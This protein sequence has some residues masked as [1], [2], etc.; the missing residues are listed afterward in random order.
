MKDLAKFIGIQYEPIL[1]LPSINGTILT[2]DKYQIIGKI[3]Q[4]VFFLLSKANR[5]I[6]IAMSEKMYECIYANGV[7]DTG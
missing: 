1:A 4:V 5:R 3:N 2:N 7:P 6:K